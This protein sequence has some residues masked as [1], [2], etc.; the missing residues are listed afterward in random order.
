MVVPPGLQDA[1]RPR[2]TTSPGRFPFWDGLSESARGAVPL[3]VLVGGLQ[4]DEFRVIAPD[5]GM[6]R[7]RLGPVGG[8]DPGA[9]ERRGDAEDRR[10]R[11]GRRGAAR[12]LALVGQIE[13]RDRLAE[14][15]AAGQLVGID[16]PAGEA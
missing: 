14:P 3:G 2:W 6:D 15:A 11:G 10:P 5:V 16:E 12:V 4:A 1:P 8:P 13:P 7:L 9:A